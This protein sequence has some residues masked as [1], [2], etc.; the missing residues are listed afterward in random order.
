MTTDTAV[1]V[2]SEIL[3][4][5]MSI[6]SMSFVKN[7]EIS[8]EDNVLPFLDTTFNFKKL[9]DKKHPLFKLNNLSEYSKSDLFDQDKWN[10]DN[11]IHNL[12]A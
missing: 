6:D 11:I 7:P 10:F 1:S 5:G 12:K 4:L 8:T 3:E 2:T 9:A